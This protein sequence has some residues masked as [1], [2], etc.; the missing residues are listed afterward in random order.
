MS[1]RRHEV[2]IIVGAR[3]I[4]NWTEYQI[5]T[6]LRDIDSFSMTR[7][8]DFGAW[9]ECRR[10]A[11]V[12]VLI[13]NAPRITGHIDKR[14]WNPKENT[15]TV[16]GRCLRGRLRDESVPR[17]VF[18][19]KTVLDV[20][21]EAVKPWF[22]KTTIT[23]ARNRRV[24]LGRGAKAPAFEEPIPLLKSAAK[25][26]IRIEPGQPK[27]E[28]VNRVLSRAGLVGWGSAD[29]TEFFIGKPN[30]T[31]AALFA[32]CHSKLATVERPLDIL[33]DEDNTKRYS[34]IVAVG[35][36]NT[37][38]ADYGEAVGG[39]AGY[40]YDDDSSAD[41]TGRD[42][43]FSKRLILGERAIRDDDEASRIAGAEQIVRDFERTGL[44]VTMP[45][46]G[47]VLSG[48]QRALYAVDTIAGVILEDDTGRVI[49]DDDFLIYEAS[50]SSKR[51]AGEQTKLRMVPRGTELV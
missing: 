44:T 38:G 33:Y 1:Q 8:F 11:R 26:K 13:D 45:N 21:G 17:S 39:R 47:Q 19:G 34:M 18:A 10:D 51:G 24:T 35:A 32:I 12:K 23:N 28:V 20:V 31:Q 3:Q 4:S 30:Q 37:D 27:L 29:G 6:S 2:T 16:I 14:S 50:F 49:V 41:G 22:Q 15:M 43:L 9:N 36:G 25:K 42:F 40:V 7:A 46:H 5:D 48:S